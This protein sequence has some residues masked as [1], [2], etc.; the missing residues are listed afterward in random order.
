[1]TANNTKDPLT[2]GIAVIGLVNIFGEG[3]EAEST[4][5]A[6]VES[7]ESSYKGK[8]ISAAERAL[9][10]KLGKAAS[11]GYTSAFQRVQKGSAAALVHD[12]MSN[13]ARVARGAV[14]TDVYNAA[15]QGIR[16]ENATGKFMGFLEAGQ[17]T[18]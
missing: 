11:R 4:I 12:I 17:A 16:F 10:K 18:R 9:D 6:V 15:G 8:A 3:G 7:A 5:K 1:M 2:F 13:P 14:T